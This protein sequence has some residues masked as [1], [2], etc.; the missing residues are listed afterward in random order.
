MHAT[1]FFWELERF[2]FERI[3]YPDKSKGHA[4]KGLS[5]CAYSQIC[6]LQS[7]THYLCIRNDIVD[8][9][10]KHLLVS[11]MYKNL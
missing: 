3:Y 9:I 10:L 7:I 5:A 11:A 1:I 2:K 6:V 4:S 8:A